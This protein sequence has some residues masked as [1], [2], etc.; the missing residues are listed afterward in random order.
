MRISAIIVHTF[1][2]TH[3]CHR[4]LASVKPCGYTN[5]R[6]I[7]RYQI[8]QSQSVSRLGT[9]GQLQFR[10]TVVNHGEFARLIDVMPERT[11]IFAITHIEST[12]GCPTT[13][14]ALS[15][16]KHRSLLRREL[17]RVKR[18]S[19]RGIKDFRHMLQFGGG[20]SNK[21]GN[22]TMAVHNIRL[23]AAQCSP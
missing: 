4:I 1:G 3:E 12:C 11:A 10:D 5:N 9:S 2:D 13:H 23:D 22:R 16:S 14:H 21:P 20:T 7:L 8:I 6:H 19:M 17:R 18:I 15:Q